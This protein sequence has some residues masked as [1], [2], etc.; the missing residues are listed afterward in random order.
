VQQNMK[1]TMK[2]VIHMVHPR[3][4]DKKRAKFSM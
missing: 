3:T 4:Y 1:I 2:F